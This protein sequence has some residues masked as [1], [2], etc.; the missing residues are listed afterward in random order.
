MAS[1]VRLAPVQGSDGA[2][3]YPSGGQ[4]SSLRSARCDLRRALRRRARP[5]AWGK[6]R[7]V[8]TTDGPR[9][10]EQGRPD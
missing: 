1:Q 4:F 8:H 9:L 6:M 3:V 2:K 10:R 7:S 5:A